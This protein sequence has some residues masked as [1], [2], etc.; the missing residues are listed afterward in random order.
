MVSSCRVQPS[1]F[2]SISLTGSQGSGAEASPSPCLSPS[3]CP[4]PVRGR[5]TLNEPPAHRGPI[6]E[7]QVITEIQQPV[8]HQGTAEVGL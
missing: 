8:A 2:G 7:R 6:M 5:V 1:S 4:C 3:P